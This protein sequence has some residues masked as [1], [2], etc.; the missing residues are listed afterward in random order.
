MNDKTIP[1]AKQFIND[2]DVKAVERV[3][4]S[5]L[6][7]QGPEA[8][9]FEEVF[10]KF[11]NSKFATSICNGTAALHLCACTLGIKPGDKIITTP[12]TFVASANGFRYCGAE[13]IFCDIDPQTYLLDLNKLEDILKKYPI[14]TIKAVVPVDF[15]GY[16]FD[17]ESLKIL[18]N[19]YQFKIVEDACHAPGAWFIDTKKNKTICGNGK[20]SDMTVFSFHPAKHITAGEGGM[21]TTNQESYFDKVNFFRTHGIKK[22]PEV[23]D[24]D[25]GAWYQE[26]QELGYNYRITDFQAA[27]GYSQLQRIDWNLQRRNEIAKRYDEAFSLYNQIVT[28]YRASNIYHAFHLYVIQVEKR[29]ELFDFLI[30]SRIIPQ[31]H[32]CPAHLMPYY[33]QDGWKEGDFPNAENY[34]NHCLSLPMYPTLT[35]EEQQWV[36]DKVIEFVTR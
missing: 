18:A 26:M 1:Y 13:V 16:P 8:K 34:Y 27:L 24:D 31:I 12:I 9:K 10:A 19:K 5:E 21:I 22:Y 2:K 32:Y 4:Y 17:V 20:Y 6:I 7:T 33:K 14:G 30:S 35:D 25:S 15:A 28:P 23:G 29:K 3:L 36:I 11:S